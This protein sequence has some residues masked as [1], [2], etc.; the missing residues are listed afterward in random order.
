[1]LKGWQDDGIAHQHALH[2]TSNGREVEHNK[3]NICGA[4]LAVQGSHWTSTGRR[5]A[6]AWAQML[7]LL[8][9]LGVLGQRAGSCRHLQVCFEQ[10]HDL[11]L[12]WN[13]TL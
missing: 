12:Y 4:H 10:H 13:R 6:L 7:L 11:M 3:L 8:V 2:I 5:C 1:M 9:V